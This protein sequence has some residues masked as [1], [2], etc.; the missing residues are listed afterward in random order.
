MKIGEFGLIRRLTR[1]LKKRSGLLVGVGDDCAVVRPVAGKPMLLTTD[2]LIEGI[3]FRR[4]WMTAREI[5]EKSMLVNL[6]DIAAMGGTP[7]YALV[8]VGLP[9]NFG[10]REATSLFGGLR[11]VAE[12][13]GV[14]IIG[15]DTNASRMLVINVTVVGEAGGQRIPTRSRARV[16][17]SIW[18]TG[19]LGQSAL[20]LQALRKNRRKG[21]EKFIA[22]HKK[23]PCRIHVGKALADNPHVHSMIDLSDGLLGDLGHILKASG[24]GAEIVIDSI[25]VQVSFFQKVRQL[26]LDPDFLKLS[27]GEDY[28]LL[29]TASDRAAIGDKIAGV[30]VTKIGSIS[31]K[32]SGMKLVDSQGR[33]YRAKISGFDHLKEVV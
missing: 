6:S 10:L 28:E 13:E 21:C 29:F 33:R 23:P 1:H 18:V 32:Q 17:D 19:T 4:E 20:G 16:G 2:M 15:G 25:P 11:R 12:R 7:L 31:P 27:G 30:R 3:H 26:A 14:S 5:G 24:V 8:S 9:K 22:S